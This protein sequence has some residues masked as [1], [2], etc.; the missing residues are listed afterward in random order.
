MKKRIQFNKAF[1]PCAILSVLI[2][3][4]GIVSIAT[5]GINFS[6][7]FKSGY[8]EEVQIA[9]N[10]SVESV[11]SALSGISGVA[12]KAIGSG[13]S[14]AFQV[15]IGADEQNDEVLKS[16]NDALANAFTKESLTVLK[17]DFI[18]SSLSHT[19]AFQSILL[20]AGTML[21]IWAYATIRFRWDFALGAIIALIHDTLIMFSFLAIFQV[22]F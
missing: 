8:I 22:E 1:L 15:R 14:A 2:I 12:V 21:C 6:I 3:A 9:S 5:R 11:R 4:F 20:L 18:G 10:P 19:L 17:T 7:D 13:E 16:V